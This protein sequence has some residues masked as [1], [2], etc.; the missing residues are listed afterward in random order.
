MWL[1]DKMLARLCE[2]GRA[3]RHRPMTARPIATASPI[4]SSTPVTVRLADAGRAAPDRPRSRARRGR[5]LY[6]RPAG[7]RG[8]RHPRPRQHHPR[9]PQMGGQRR[10]ATSFLRKGGKLGN[11]LNQLNWRERSQRNVAH[12]YDVGN[13]FYRLFLDADLQY[14]CGYF[15]RSRQHL[16]QAQLDKKTHLAAKLMPRAGPEGARHRLRLGRPRALPRTRSRTSRCSASPCRRSSSSSPAQR[17]AEPGVADR[18]KFELIDYRDVDGPFDRIVSV[19]MFEHVGQPHSPHLF[20][21]DP[22]PAQ[23]TTAWRCSTRW[24]GWAARARP[25]SSCRNTSSPAAIC[26]LCP[27]SSRRASRRS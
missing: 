27:R 13:D 9:Q 11:R 26:R 4:P 15:T 3:D 10:D 21:Q 12:H 8:G 19:G 24:R 5:G 18:V 25:T 16:E 1:L 2:E 23:P 22:R 14:S 20:P 7:G 17:A 6:G